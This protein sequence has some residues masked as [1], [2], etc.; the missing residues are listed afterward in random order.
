VPPS[1]LAE[2]SATFKKILFPII[3]AG[4]VGLR[5]MGGGI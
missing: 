4:T 1:P 3:P 2:A 5:I